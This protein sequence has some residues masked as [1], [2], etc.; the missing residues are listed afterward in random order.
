LRRSVVT[1]G[2]FRLRDKDGGHRDTQFEL[3]YAKTPCFTQ[4]SR[5]YVV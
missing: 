3:P 4:T 2:H 5:L 1:R